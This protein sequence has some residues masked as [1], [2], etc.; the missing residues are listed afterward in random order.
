MVSEVYLLLGSDLGDS[1]EMLRKASSCI[2]S[3]AGKIIKRSKIYNS[4]AWGF[5]SDTVFYNQALCI[6]TDLLAPDLLKCLLQ[7]EIDLG[8]VRQDQIK[9]KAY[10]SRII[11]IDIIYY[12]EDIIN[13]DELKL[14]HPLLQDRR[15][16]LKPLC[17]IARYFLH[18]IFKCS[19]VE[20]LEGCKDESEVSECLPPI[21]KDYFLSVEGNIGSGKTSL[22]QKISEDYNAK[23]VLESFKDNVFLERF[24][25]NQERYA[26]PLELSFLAERYK[27]AKDEFEIDLFKSFIVSDFVIDKSLVFSKITLESDEFDLF[28]SLYDIML[29]SIPIPKLYVYLHNSVENIQKNILKRGRTFET[30][31]P[32]EYL[33]NVEN[34]YFEHI[35][36]KFGET[37][38]IIDCR[39]L[40]FVD[41]YNDYMF[42]LNEISK[43]IIKLNLDY[44]E[45]RK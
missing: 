23:L 36:T 3:E 11:D 1:I 22:T 18:P 14:P 44:Y 42:L 25:S 30:N 6:E 20:L 38:L 2:E 32:D 26:F 10:S 19:T 5:E 7:I 41:N 17:D 43:K 33:L 4:K 39:D 29:Q 31:I 34:T 45:K 16:V 35:R 27:Q 21:P 40:D 24:Y 8:R 13:T 9:D 37:A 15:F 12:N 28:R